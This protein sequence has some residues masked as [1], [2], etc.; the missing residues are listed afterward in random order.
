MSAARSVVCFVLAFVVIGGGAAGCSS[1]EEEDGGEGSALSAADCE[2]KAKT[3]EDKDYKDCVGAEFDYD[4]CVQPAYSEYSNYL[5][6][7][8]TAYAAA[9]RAAN[10]ANASWKSIDEQCVEGAKS[11]D[12]ATLLASDGYEALKF[13]NGKGNQATCETARADAIQTC[14]EKVKN[15]A[16]ADP[17]T[18]PARDEKYSTLNGQWL[19]KRAS[20]LGTIVSCATQQAATATKDAVFCQAKSKATY[21]SVY[22]SCRHECPDVKHAACTPDDY[23]GQDVPCGTLENKKEY[24]GVTCESSYECKRSDVCNA[25]DKAIKDAPNGP[26]CKDGK[27]KLFTVK[28][29]KVDSIATPSGIEME[30][31]D[32][33]E[34][35]TSANVI[36]T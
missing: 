26:A 29:K 20:W 10:A 22:A 17:S 35:Q 12:C 9:S 3:A 8:E 33:A 5:K 1:A 21:A 32:A 18:D 4:A 11:A 28:T 16:K 25:Y 27:V 36:T 7:L 15:D 31:V 14:H 30:C 2:P 23:K 24:F 13:K 34:T 6:Q 19:G